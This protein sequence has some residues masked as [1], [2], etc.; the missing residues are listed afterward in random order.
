ML[1]AGAWNTVACLV[2]TL[3][4]EGLLVFVVDSRHR[5]YGLGPVCERGRGSSRP[6]VFSDECRSFST[7]QALLSADRPA[8]RCVC[9]GRVHHCAKALR[10]TACVGRTSKHVGDVV[11]A[12][13]SFQALSRRVGGTH[14]LPWDPTQSRSSRSRAAWGHARP[15]SVLRIR[16][17]PGTSSC[18]PRCSWARL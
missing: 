7:L 3:I 18:T 6:C 17:A 5:L 15:L 9:A 2:S 12:R 11:A 13:A 16:A 1:K 4:K 8:V 14:M 10:R